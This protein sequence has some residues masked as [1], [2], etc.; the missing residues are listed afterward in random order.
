VTATNLVIGLAVLGLVIYRQVIARPVRSNMRILAILAVIGVY[1]AYQYLHGV[2]ADAVLAGALAG[3]LVLAAVFGVL[4]AA[5]VKLSWRQGQ[6][7]MQGSWLTALLW[8]VSLGSHL[9]F[10]ALAGH[11]HG[12]AGL[13]DATIVLYLAVT[14]GVQRAVVQLRTQRMAVPSQNGVTGL[15]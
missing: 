11:H 5:T 15:A 7:W 2:H 12:Y 13:G 14:Y 1:Q 4:R 8:I 10:D 6:W 9:G 3:S